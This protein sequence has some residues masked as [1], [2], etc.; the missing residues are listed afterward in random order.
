MKINVRKKGSV[1]ILDVDGDVVGGPECE[2]LRTV[3]RRLVDEGQR[4]FLFNLERVRLLNSCGLGVIIGALVTLRKADGR[5]KVCAFN[6]R[7]RNTFEVI[8]LPLIID[9]FDDE[10]RALASFSKQATG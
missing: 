5:L 3:V 2:V 7:I 9:L 6:E 1:A 4:D 10:D 8:R